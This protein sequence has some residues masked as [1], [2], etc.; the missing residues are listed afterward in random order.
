MSEKLNQYSKRAGTRVRIP[1][2]IGDTITNWNETCA[3]AIVM[4]GLPGDKF[5]THPT[6]DHLDFIFKDEK[7]A[8]MFEL[9]CG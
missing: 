3:Q 8:M 5:T 1:W 6:K 9:C 4:F 7:D 2:K